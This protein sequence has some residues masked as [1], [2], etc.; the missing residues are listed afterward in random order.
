MPEQI[1]SFSVGD[2]VRH[3][4]HGGQVMTV[5]EVFPTIFQYRFRC[6][7]AEG[8][9]VRRQLFRADELEEAERQE[10]PGT[11]N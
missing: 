11:M 8:G 5:E 4:V 1:T 10:D 6:E 9:R 7:W 3:R 2:R